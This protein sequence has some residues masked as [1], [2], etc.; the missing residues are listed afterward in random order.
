MFD[1][2]DVELDWRPLDQQLREHNELE[3]KNTSKKDAEARGQ[4]RPTNS[5]VNDRSTAVLSTVVEEDESNY[6]SPSTSFETSK[7]SSKLSLADQTVLSI[8]P[9]VSEEKSS[10]LTPTSNSHSRDEFSFDASVFERLDAVSPEPTLDE[11]TGT[12]STTDETGAAK[13]NVATE[14]SSD[15]P[16]SVTTSTS[17]H[18][19]KKVTK[20]RVMAKMQGRYISRYTPPSLPKLHDKRSKLSFWGGESIKE[21]GDKPDS[22]KSKSFS[23]GEKVSTPYGQAVVV[24]HRHKS[25]IVV[26]DLIGWTSNL[27]RAYLQESVIKREGSSFL[28]SILRSF[29][30]AGDK[31][32][33]PLKKTNSAEKQFPHVTGTKIYTP[34]GEGIVTRPIPVMKRVSSSNSLASLTSLTSLTSL[35]KSKQENSGINTMAISITSWTMGNGRHPTLYCTVDSAKEWKNKKYS[36]AASHKRENSLFS[37]LGSLVSGTV[38]SLSKKIRVPREIDAPK[39]EVV[40]YERYYKDG[41]AVTTAYG[42]GTVRSFRESD[43]F[44]TVSLLSKSGMP[45]ATAHLQED[46]MSYRLAKGCVEGYPVYTKFGLSG[47]LQSV[48]PTTGVHNVFIPSC[49]AICYLQPDQVIRPIKA[50]VSEDVST[51]YG[52]GKVMKYRLQDDTYEIRLVWSNAMLYAKAAT[53]D[54]IDDRMEDKGGF[55]MGWILKFFYSREESKDDGAPRSRSNSVSMLSQSGRSAKSAA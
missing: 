5:K 35:Q 15:V 47:V 48:N 38:E 17:S 46:S 12:M 49:G 39:I 3:A 52:E 51:Q 29:S 45:F 7:H 32:G 6:L 50:A 21:K 43:G 19:T 18:E 1:L 11:T 23:A 34:F 31:P 25:K 33:S 16:L 26:V 22:T 40:K 27:A 41:A 8:P 2:Y 10:N 30:S 9:A 14:S 28:G 36:T 37:A 24:E 42:D 13:S 20:G 53:F 54:R 55:G 44:Y 4:M